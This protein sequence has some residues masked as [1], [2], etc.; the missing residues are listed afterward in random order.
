MTSEVAYTSK[1]CIFTVLSNFPPLA[2]DPRSLGD[3]FTLKFR[4]HH[5]N[6]MVFPVEASF[7]D[8]L[9][10]LLPDLETDLYYCYTIYI[11]FSRG[12]CKLSAPFA[13]IVI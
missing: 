8:L 9:V 12:C 11:I 7:C 4:L 6:K 5:N 1:M 10:K 13:L 3:R 2:T